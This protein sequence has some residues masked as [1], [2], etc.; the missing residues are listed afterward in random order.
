MLD[1]ARIA[2]VAAA[3]AVSR[4]EAIGHLS[5]LYLWAQRNGLETDLERIDDRVISDAVE[6][7]DP[8][9][10]S[11]AENYRGMAFRLAVEELGP[12]TVP[13]RVWPTQSVRLRRAS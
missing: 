3:L 7:T 12:I 8:E 9:D 13:R 6:F 5:R 11:R 10:T 1:E 4:I 2:H